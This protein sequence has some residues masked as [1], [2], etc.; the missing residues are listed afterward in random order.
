MGKG[1]EKRIFLICS[2]RGAS[3]EEKEEFKNYK[4][5]KE[6]EGYSVH[7]PNMDTNQDDEI[8]YDICVTNRKV[9]RDSNEVHLYWKPTSEGSRFD[10]SMAFMADKKLVIVNENK[11]VEEKD[12]YTSFLIEYANNSKPSGLYKKFIENKG[13]IVKFKDPI[14]INI[15]AEKITKEEYQNAR[16]LLG[17]IFMAEMPIGLINA[18]KLR[19]YEIRQDLIKINKHVESIKSGKDDAELVTK[20]FNKVILCYNHVCKGGDKR[21]FYDNYLAERNRLYD[22]SKA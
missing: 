9:I 19:D 13:D 7:N 21:D 5:V 15:D 20:N 8:G 12:E 4:E 16:Y 3:K 10:L 22:E 6:K 14:S 2:V 1:L 17:M 11:L 18:S